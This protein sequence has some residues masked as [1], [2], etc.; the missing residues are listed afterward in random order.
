MNDADNPRGSTARNP[1]RVQV[2]SGKR[3]RAVTVARRA[4][5]VLSLALAACGGGGG[6]GS[7]DSWG[8]GVFDD[9]TALIQRSW[10]LD[11]GT[12]GFFCQRIRIEKD[13]Y[14]SAF[15]TRAPA[16][17]HRMHLSVS[18]TGTPLGDYD[19]NMAV[20]NGEQMVFGGGAGSD[21][22]EFPAGVAVKL[23]AGK[24][25]NLIVHAHNSSTTS[26]LTGTSGVFVKTVPAS[27]VQHEA[28][29]IFLGT[30]DLHIPPTNQP[31]IEPGSCVLPDRWT[32]VNLWPVMNRYGKHQKV[33][34]RRGDNRIETLL[35]ADH[36]PSAQRNYPLPSTV[37]E[38]N[39]E[40]RVECTYVNDTNITYPPGSEIQYA[41]SVIG[42]M[43]FTGLY[44]YPTGG[45]P[46]FC[47]AF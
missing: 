14:V 32:I 8:G 45:T 33:T 22:I 28:D 15:Q 4:A 25:L 37:F 18:S 2:R 43:C 3:D 29:M 27:E 26:P 35:D 20:I 10:S 38:P 24:Y 23:P 1:D 17:T 13:T 34:V 31:W 41:E 46:Y 39:D 30:F 12:E 7:S 9:W 5:L 11:P 40:L 42:E 19:C 6:G 16:G 47:A 44:K 36:S 21:D